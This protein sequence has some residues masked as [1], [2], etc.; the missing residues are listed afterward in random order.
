MVLPSTAI[1][2]RPKTCVDRVHNQAPRTLSSV[3][4]LTLANARRNVDSSAAPRR[5]PPRTQ[6]AQHIGTGLS[7]PLTDRGERT[8]TRDHRGDPDREQP[9]QRMPPTPFLTGI[10]NLGQQIKQV[11]TTRGRHRNGDRRR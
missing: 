2:N 6:R 10:R 7:G 3:S 11:Q 9:G 1:T 8:R 5:A 4:A